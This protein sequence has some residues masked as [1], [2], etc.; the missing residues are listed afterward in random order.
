MPIIELNDHRPNPTLEGPVRCLN[1]GHKWRHVGPT[2]EVR[3]IWC[4]ACKTKK[5]V[6]MYATSPSG[7]CR[8][9]CNCGC[10]LFFMLPSGQLQCFI[11][12]LA[13]NTGGEF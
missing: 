7:D 1:C 4:P 12:G 2:G 10:D 6:F 8:Y 5:G 3:E 9:V 13:H 11:C